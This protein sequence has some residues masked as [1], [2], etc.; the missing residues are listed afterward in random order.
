VSLAVFRDRLWDLALVLGGV[1]IVARVRARQSWKHFEAA[2]R[3]DPA[4]NA[5]EITSL[6][7]WDFRYWN[8]I[9]LVAAELS[10]LCSG[11]W[12]MSKLIYL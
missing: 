3:A 11:V 9:G 6:R 10:I 4:H 1:S 8:R 12:L 2:L 7:E 5:G